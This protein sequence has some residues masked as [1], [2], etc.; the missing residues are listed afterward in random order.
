VQFFLSEKRNGQRVIDGLG[1]LKLVGRGKCDQN[2]ALSNFILNKE[3]YCL[4]DLI[5]RI[6]YKG[7]FKL[8]FIVILFHNSK[9]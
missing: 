6:R 7:E 4:G 8:A 1:W 5:I 2:C 9:I 3:F